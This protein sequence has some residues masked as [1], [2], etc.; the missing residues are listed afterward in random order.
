MNPN[1]LVTL[2]D[3]Y[4]LVVLIRVLISWIQLPPDNPI[5]Q[6]AR[7]LTEPALQ[8]I[9]KLLPPSGGLDFSPLILL[10]F[11]RMLSGTFVRM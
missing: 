4:S 11:L 6:Y 5:V 7:M 9:R 2:I 1:P 8:P 10:L 3:L